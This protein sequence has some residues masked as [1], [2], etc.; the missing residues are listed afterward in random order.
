[1]RELEKEN[2]PTEAGHLDKIQARASFFM[3]FLLSNFEF[4]LFMPV[5]SLAAISSH[6]VTKLHHAALVGFDLHQMERDI[7]VELLEE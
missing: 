5:P 4:L 1:V 2:R 6:L 7:S 3:S